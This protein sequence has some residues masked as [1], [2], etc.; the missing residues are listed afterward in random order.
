MDPKN[1]KPEWADRHFP[2]DCP[3]DEPCELC[4][5]VREA[6]EE[7]EAARGD[8]LYDAWKDSRNER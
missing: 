2:E 8:A 3:D 4:M 6:W 7:R 1:E 5:D